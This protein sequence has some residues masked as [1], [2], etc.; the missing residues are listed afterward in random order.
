MRFNDLLKGGFIMI[1]QR[2][3]TYRI[4]SARWTLRKFIFNDR[5]YRQVAVFLE[6]GNGGA[7]GWD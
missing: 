5:C 1:L 7:W 2:G 6:V 4:G 3:K